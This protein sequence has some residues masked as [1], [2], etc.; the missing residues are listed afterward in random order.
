MGQCVRPHRPMKFLN[1]HAV[2]TNP[3][4]RVVRRYGIQAALS[5]ND[6]TDQVYNT[7]ST[8]E[9]SLFHPLNVHISVIYIFYTVVLVPMSVRSINICLYHYNGV[10]VLPERFKTYQT[11]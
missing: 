1:S 10:V 8:A 4:G 6:S 3:A 5:A 9:T 11:K 7:S 2:K